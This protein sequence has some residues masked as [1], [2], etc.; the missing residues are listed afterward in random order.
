MSKKYVYDKSIFC[1]PVTKA[2][3]LSSIQFIINDFIKKG[4]TFCVDGE[5]D[6]WEIWRLVEE[7]DSEKIKKS[8]MPSRPKYLYVS[9]DPI[10]DF[11]VT[12]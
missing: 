9:G 3:P 1:I 11:E 5:N 6:Q 12:D 7:D 2:E 8:G 10:E 4:I